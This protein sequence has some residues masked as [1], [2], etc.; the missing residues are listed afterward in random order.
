MVDQLGTPHFLGGS[1]GRDRS[2]CVAPAT[3][4]A[5]V[6][7]VQVSIS[8]PASTQV[9]DP[10]RY[11]IR[12]DNSGNK[13][14]SGVEV[15][16]GLPE[17]NTSPTVHVKGIVGRLHRKCSLQGTSVVCD[18]GKVRQGRSKTLWF[19]IALPTSSVPMQIDA[20][21]T[22]TTLED[23]TANNSASH[24]SSHD[25]TLNADHPISF[26]NGLP[27]Y[28]GVWQQV[29]DD[30]LALAYSFNGQLVAGFHGYG[31][32]GDCFEGITLF[33]G[34]SYNSAYSVCLQ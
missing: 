32:G 15:T 19:E 9:Y 2:L 7:D 6:P 10:A 17:T 24:V 20:N 11:S 18:F 22:T 21:V 13:D 29:L 23:N 3:H 27:G 30:R 1:S 25:I 8:A 14:A 26:A 31:V 5:R 12:V 33:P 34:S 4:A 28:T 16:I